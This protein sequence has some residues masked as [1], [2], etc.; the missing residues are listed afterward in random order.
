M[1]LHTQIAA[2]NDKAR[3]SF[4]GCRLYITQGISRFAEEDQ[5]IIFSK[6]RTF[7]EFNEDNDPYGEHDFGSFS[8]QGQ[9]I[10]WKFDYYD[11]LDQYR[12][13]DPSNTQITNRVLTILLAEE[14]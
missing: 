12:S 14:Y 9:K 13:P 11:T 7:N 8:Y 6:V 1:T 3:S 10:Y 4:Q 5:E 2:L